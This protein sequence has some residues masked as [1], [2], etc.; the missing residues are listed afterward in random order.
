MELTDIAANRLL[1]I[2]VLTAIALVLLWMTEDFP[3]AYRFF[4]ALAPLVT[5]VLGKYYERSII[6]QAELVDV[7]ELRELEREKARVLFK[8]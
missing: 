3:V 2:G 8:S 7:E 6:I 4:V 1:H 5:W